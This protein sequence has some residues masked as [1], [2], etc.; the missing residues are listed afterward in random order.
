MA[1]NN[2]GLGFTVY[3]TNQAT[4]VFAKVTASMRGMYRQGRE[5]QAS[6]A[7]GAASMAASFGLIRVGLAGVAGIRNVVAEAREFELGMAKV[8]K[9][10][11]ASTKPKVLVKTGPATSTNTRVSDGQAASNFEWPS[12]LAATAQ[13]GA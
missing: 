3:A 2:L 9:A 10:T 1:L 6:M 5:A 7:N 13:K 8:T 11:V 4:P 12:D